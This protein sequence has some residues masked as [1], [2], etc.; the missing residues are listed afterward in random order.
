MGL[1]QHTLSQDR[2]VRSSE[3][4]AVC[5]YT[6]LSVVSEASSD[7]MHSSS[8]TTAIVSTYPRKL[9]SANNGNNKRKHLLQFIIDLLKEGH[10][11]V[12]WSNKKE[13]EF[14]IEQPEKLALLWATYKNN[15]KMTFDSL[16]RSLRLYY[17]PKKLERIS[18]K[19]NHYRILNLSH[20]I[21][22]TL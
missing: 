5:K 22:F 15:N 12:N 18:G 3:S 14:F 2:R 21:S 20:E 13:K 16:A 4:L 7:C 11:C 6:S 8:T 17:A 9:Q 19:K 10:S 1:D